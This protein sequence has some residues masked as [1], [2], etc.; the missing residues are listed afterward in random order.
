MK[1]K[2][3][4]CLVALFYFC[5]LFFFSSTLAQETCTI[6]NANFSPSGTLPDF[7][8]SGGQISI[9]VKTAN[10]QGKQIELTV[11]GTRDDEFNLNDHL[12]MVSSPLTV[13]KLDHKIISVPN[14]GN[15]KVNLIANEESCMG[16]DSWSER[17]GVVSYTKYDCAFY[18]SFYENPQDASIIFN[19]FGSSGGSIIYNC[20]GECEDQQKPWSFISTTGLENNN[21]NN[22]NSNDDTVI[23]NNNNNTN[24]LHITTQLPQDLSTKG[25]G[26]TAAC[27]KTGCGFNELL[28]MVNKVVKFV[29]F[30]L[31]IPI[32]AIMFTY[33]GIIL[34]IS[35]G[36]PSKKTKA[37]EIFIGVVIGL[38][39]AAAAWLIV[40]TILKTLGYNGSWIGF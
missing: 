15:F 1:I 19:S 30:D 27:P 26:L 16:R 29:I 37:K 28:E 38:V 6:Q 18:F 4:I 5:S 11:F 3:L 17:N 20:L 2:F 36:D 39:V 23:L 7:L 13:S 22:T 12:G 10:C 24:T 25:L 35:G 14:S 40:E 21:G 34:L 32:A 9:D 8:Q 31:A 33:A